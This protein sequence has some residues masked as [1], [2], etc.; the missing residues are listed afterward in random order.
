[1]SGLK[2]T[3]HPGT[4]WEDCSHVGILGFNNHYLLPHSSCL[5]LY[6]TRRFCSCVTSTWLWVSP[7]RCS[8]TLWRSTSALTAIQRR[9]QMRLSARPE[10]ATG[11]WGVTQ[12]RSTCT[13]THHFCILSLNRQ[14]KQKICFWKAFLSVLIQPSSIEHAPWCYYPEDYGYNVTS[15]LE[16]TSG[17]T[18]DITRNQKYGSS[19]RPGSPDIDTLRVEI[20]YHS[21]DMLQFKVCV[22]LFVASCD[23]FSC[24]SCFFFLSVFP[25]TPSLYFNA[26]CFPAHTNT[27]T[28]EHPLTVQIWD[29]STERY[30]VPVPLSIP[31][32]PETDENN[33]L[34]KVLVTNNPFGIQ[35][36]RKSTG[37][38]MWVF[39]LHE[40]LMWVQVVVV[41]WLNVFCF[42]SFGFIAS[43]LGYLLSFSFF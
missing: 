23:A 32:T 13:C 16:T 20:R 7:I 35:I 8:G 43:I 19:G 25:Y 12:M 42:M 27:L 1:M 4:T 30:E 3:V 31:A 9:M 22:Y 21:S 36:I 24:V 2:K 33:R 41:C 11:R 38:T 39:Q 37:T 17:M 29:P 40:W 14:K 5:S 34:Y 15:S 26:S 10:A 28:H 6:H 18:V